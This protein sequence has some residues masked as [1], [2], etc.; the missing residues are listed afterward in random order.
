[1]LYFNQTFQILFKPETLYLLRRADMKN[2]KLKPMKIM[3][4]KDDEVTTT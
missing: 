2:I 4:A 1:M 3:K